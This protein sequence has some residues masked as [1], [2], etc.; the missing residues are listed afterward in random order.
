MA[1][2]F[3]RA[4]LFLPM[5]VHSGIYEKVQVVAKSLELHKHDCNLV[6]HDVHFAQS[7]NLQ[8]RHFKGETENNLFSLSFAL[9]SVFL[10]N[11]FCST[12]KFNLAYPCVKDSDEIPAVG[13]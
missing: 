7:A 11:L 6:G 10:K 4:D 2:E 9:K 3:D 13:Y 12:S 1:G 5:L 8:A